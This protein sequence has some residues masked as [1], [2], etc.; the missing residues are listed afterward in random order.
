MSLTTPAV[1]VNPD[2]EVREVDLGAGADQLGA[3]YR[4]IGC[5]VLD[6]LTVTPQLLLWVD[7]KGVVNGSPVNTVATALVAATPQLRSHTIRGTVVFTGAA[8]PHGD[9]T[10]LAPEWVQVLH[11]HHRGKGPT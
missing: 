1:S 9:V 8:D 11:A 4:A 3:L 10:A 5:D 6:L 2:G 7:D